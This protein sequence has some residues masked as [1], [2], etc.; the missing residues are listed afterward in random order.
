MA[1]K[2]PALPAYKTSY[3]AFSMQDKV[4]SDILD[5]KKE[6]NAALQAVNIIEMKNRG[7]IGENEPKAVVFKA[8]VLSLFYVLKDKLHYPKNSVPFDPLK[9]LEPYAKGQKSQDEFTVREAK[10]YFSLMCTFI[11]V[12]GITK[13]EREKDDT[14]PE[15]IMAK[16]ASG[17]VHGTSSENVSAYERSPKKL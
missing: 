13:F 7:R 9:N 4:R 11:E 14:P 2:P 5:T 12:D 3:E 6:A 1:E 15:F 17:V 10:Y 8:T 16:L